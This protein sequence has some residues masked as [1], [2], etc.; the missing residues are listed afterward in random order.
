[1]IA[2][3]YS[4]T[5][6]LCEIGLQD[7]SMSIIFHVALAQMYNVITYFVHLHLYMHHVVQQHVYESI[8]CLTSGSNL[9]N[10]TH[11][12]TLSIS[13]YPTML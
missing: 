9:G 1:M 11:Y 12:G 3:N 13:G 4:V 8:L 6:L 10:P 5:F 7:H 2:Y